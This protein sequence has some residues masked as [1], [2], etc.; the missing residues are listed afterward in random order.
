MK[1]IPFLL[2]ACFVFVHSPMFKHAPSRS[3]AKPNRDITDFV[4]KG[5]R[6]LSVI[7]PAVA[8]IDP[9]TVRWVQDIARGVRRPE[10]TS[11]PRR[12]SAA[13]LFGCD[14]V[15]PSAEASVWFV[16]ND[17]GNDLPLRILAY[18][19]L[20]GLKGRRHP[21]KPYVRS[22]HKRT[23]MHDRLDDSQ[24]EQVDLFVMD[25]AGPVYLVLSSYRPKLWSLQLA[26]GVKLEAVAVIG[27]GAQALAH[28]PDGT[29]VRFVTA[30][31]SGQQNCIV[32]PAPP[33]N[34]HWRMFEWR[35]STR[36]KRVIENQRAYHREYHAWLVERVGEPDHV[37]AVGSADYMLIGPR[38][39][40]PVPYRSL[41][42]AHVLFAPAGWPAW[43]TRKVAADTLFQL[44]Q[45][46]RSR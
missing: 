44:V 24:A 25:T 19:G 38:P 26:G 9:D 37:I 40:E 35:K 27:A 32:T 39:E 5:N 17:D 31:G 4:G 45:N 16:Y 42:D 41:K 30:H 15:R 21:L 33:V 7:S 1:A 8:T 46:S 29:P 2:L 11:P 23:D 22:G 10:V 34:E 13:S 36:F 12:F 20:P 14:L 3:L 18:Q 28:L 6:G 43:G